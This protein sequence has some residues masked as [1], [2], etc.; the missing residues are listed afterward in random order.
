MLSTKSIF[1]L[2]MIVSLKNAHVMQSNTACSAYGGLLHPSYD[3]CCDASCGAR[4]CGSVDCD[5]SPLGETACCGTV[6]L[7]MRRCGVYNK[8]ASCKL[9]FEGH[10][11]MGTQ[12]IRFSGTGGITKVDETTVGKTDFKVDGSAGARYFGLGADLGVGYKD[13]E[14]KVKNVHATWYQ[15]N[16]NMAIGIICLVA[17]VAVAIITC[18]CVH[19]V[20]RNV[21]AGSIHPYV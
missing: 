4:F 5:E 3:V 18:Y 17:I 14:N 15:V 2:A 16:A 9:D 6:I 21:R 10:S 20:N 11:N 13:S 8:Q 7:E 1:V 12:N 19:Q